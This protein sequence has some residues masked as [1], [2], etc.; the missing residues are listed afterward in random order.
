M[1]W[2]L[3][4]TSPFHGFRDEPLPLEPR[5]LPAAEYLDIWV[6]GATAAQWTQLASTFLDAMGVRVDRR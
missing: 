2:Q 4:S 6:E 3:K 5:G 1:L